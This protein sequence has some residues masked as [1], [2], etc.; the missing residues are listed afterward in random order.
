MTFADKISLGQSAVMGIIADNNLSQ[1]QFNWL[2]TVFYLSYLAFEYPQN[3]ALQKFPVGKWMSMNIFV[4][5]V[6]LMAHAACKSFGGLF[7]VRFILGMCEGAI[8]PGFLIVTS[9]FYTREEQS[10]RVGYWFLMNGA[11]AIFLGL[12]AFGFIH[13]HVCLFHLRLFSTDIIQ[14]DNFHPW[15]WYAA[16]HLRDTAISP[17]LLTRL[18]ILTGLVTLVVSGL[19]W[20]FFP[21][22][23]VSARFLT[24]EERVK[25]IQRIKVNQSGVE[26]KHWKRDQ[27][28]EALCDPKTWLLAIFVASA[29]LFNAVTNQRQ[30]IVNQFGFSLGQT[31]LL[32]TVDGA[33]EVLVIFGMVRL[34]RYVGH[35][36][37]AI[38]S[39]VP[40][41]LGGILL[42][43]LPSQNK[44]GLLF[45]Y[46]ISIFAIAPFAISL[47]W[48]NNI[49]AGHTKKTTV[50]A[51]VLIGYGIGNTAGPFMWK[52]MY[53][54]RN[55]VPWAVLTGFCG[56]S[57]FIVFILRTHLALE[58]KRR[59]NEEHDAKYDDVYVTHVE[60]DGTTVEKKVDR[61]FLD[62]T[63][64]KNREFRY[65]L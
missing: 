24:P 21:D 35:C 11:A 43:T 20:F 51:I 27:F 60:A 29:N 54:P 13:T 56:F 1:N 37:A 42:I 64:I 34:I 55:R 65:V 5:A 17:R 53:Q 47:G 22:S 52:K 3:L 44:V 40:A 25:V 50:N 33:V 31:T 48:M 14:N 39:F 46:W 62:L 10:K 30:I 16:I 2:S 7:V 4:W 38:L 26:N 9:M 6:A 32:G 49:T 12:V 19:F 41:V 28:L 57:A 23:P 59:D 15:Q 8:T 45:S 61:A 18:M 63:D 58:N 36:Y